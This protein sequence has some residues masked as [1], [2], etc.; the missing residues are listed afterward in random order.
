MLRKYRN[1]FK[2]CLM[3][4]TSRSMENSAAECDLMECVGH[5]QEVTKE[6]INMWP[7]NCDILVKNMSALCPCLKSL[8]KAKMKF[9]LNLLEE[10]VSKQPN[11]LWLLALTLIKI[12]NEKEQAEQG[13]TQNM[14]RLKKGTPGIG[15]ELNP[16]FKE[17]NRLNGV[18]TSG[19]DP[20]QLSFQLAKRN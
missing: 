18:V 11:V 7:R 12:Y 20:T 15:I 10:K 16:V 4:H 3:G 8:P 5:A 13:E 1:C 17:I 9:G 6:N 19:Q 14:Y 2:H